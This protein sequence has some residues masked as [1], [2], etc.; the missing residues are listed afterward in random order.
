MLNE[1]QQEFARKVLSIAFNGDVRVEIHFTKVDGTER[2]LIA[3]PFEQ[4]P[5]ELKPVT[6]VP[7]RVP[8]D[9]IVRIFAEK[10]QEW[11]SVKV[12]NIISMKVLL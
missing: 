2:T 6:D 12:E 10:E 4:I 8:T 1:V 11:R 7:G 9:T 3:L 5:A